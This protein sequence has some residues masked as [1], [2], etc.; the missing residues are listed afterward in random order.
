MATPL[1]SNTPGPKSWA[2]SSKSSRS[3]GPKSPSRQSPGPD[4]FDEHDLALLITGYSDGGYWLF[5]PTGRKIEGALIATSPDYGWAVARNRIDEHGR[6]EFFALD[7]A[8]RAAIEITG[9]ALPCR[10][11]FKV[12]DYYDDRHVRLRNLCPARTL[13]VEPAD[14]RSGAIYRLSGA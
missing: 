13:C 2:C 5:C 11:E 7:P 3:A 6:T 12:I 8:R 14:H 4:F 10:S 9:L 1:Y